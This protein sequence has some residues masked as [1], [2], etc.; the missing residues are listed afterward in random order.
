MMIGKAII[1]I[2]QILPLLPCPRDAGCAADEVNAAIKKI[3]RKDDR[4]SWGLITER[5]TKFENSIRIEPGEKQLLD[6]EFVVPSVVKVV[7]VYSYV[8]NEMLKDSGEI[9]WSASS[10]YDFRTPND[11]RTK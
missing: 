8:H 1:R 2:Q 10:Y 9:G 5:N 7:R 11:G 4:F 6:F 3:E